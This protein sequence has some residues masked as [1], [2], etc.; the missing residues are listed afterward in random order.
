MGP[1]WGLVILFVGFSDDRGLI[2]IWFDVAVLVVIITIII[3]IIVVWW[4]IWALR[5][6]KAFVV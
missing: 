5:V 6:G 2:F 3:I 1:S 4:V